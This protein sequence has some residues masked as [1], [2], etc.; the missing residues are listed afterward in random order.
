MLVDGAEQSL[1]DLLHRT[2]FQRED[3]ANS[4]PMVF[5]FGGASGELALLLAAA[6]SIDDENLCLRLGRQWMAELLRT[7]QSYYVQQALPTCLAALGEANQRSLCQ[8]VVE[9]IFAEPEKA[10]GVIQVLPELQKQFDEPLATEEQILSLLDGYG[11]GGYA[12]G[13]GPVLVLLP[14]EARGPAARTVWNKVAKT[15]RAS[16]LLGMITE[17]PEPA[18]ESLSTFIVESIGESLGDDASM[19]QYYVGQLSETE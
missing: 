11:E 17:L 1:R 8:Y 14:D 7:N 9:L 13:L 19:A 3:D 10:A 15:G 18:G 12:W 4:A 5:S 16:F 2:S 6:R